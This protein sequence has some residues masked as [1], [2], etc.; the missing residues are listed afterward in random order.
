MGAL[1]CFLA[2]KLA[3]TCCNLCVKK[4]EWCPAVC[5]NLL[6]FCT[7]KEEREKGVRPACR[8]ARVSECARRGG[9]ARVRCGADGG[10]VGARVVAGYRTK[11]A[12]KRDE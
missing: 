5:C 3:G 12:S 1:L 10:G 8:G 6:S 4:Y 2:C 9:R 11:R 7:A